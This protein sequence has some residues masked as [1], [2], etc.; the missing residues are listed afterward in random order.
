MQ[1]FEPAN[2]LERALQ[3]AQAGE[4]PLSD[5]LPRLWAA[6]LFAPSEEEIQ[7]DRQAFRP[8]LVPGK[9]AQLVVVFTAL[10]RAAGLH[11]T[12]PHV[13]KVAAR[14]FLPRT[15][16][17]LGLAINPGLAVGIE[18]APAGLQRMIKEFSALH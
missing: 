3:K 6:D 13:L 11:R 7:V 9:D 2:D 1:P 8:V 14:E 17:G 5:F 15:P 10:E 18:I 12:A 16:Q 4:M